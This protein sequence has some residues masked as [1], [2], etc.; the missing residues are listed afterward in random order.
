MI[1]RQGQPGFPLRVMLVA[2]GLDAGLVAPFHLFTRTR[3]YFENATVFDFVLIGIG[4]FIAVVLL[5]MIKGRTFLI[6]AASAAGMA[7]VGFLTIVQYPALEYA[8]Q[9][10][11]LVVFLGI[12]TQPMAV[13][14]AAIACL[15]ILLCS[16][17]FEAC[18]RS[19]PGEGGLVFPAALAL[20]AGIHFF[21]TLLV[22]STTGLMLSLV[23]S[24]TGL[25]IL[26]GK[27]SSSLVPWLGTKPS[28]FPV[29]A[30]RHAAMAITGM[31]SWLLST[32]IGLL[33][34]LVYFGHLKIPLDLINGSLLSSSVIAGAA[35][36]ALIAFVSRK[37]RAWGS[38][39]A[40]TCGGAGLALLF[41]MTST[42][43]L[44][45]FPVIVL[46]IPL[47]LP[48]WHVASELSQAGARG[49]T[50]PL[51]LVGWL[52]SAYVAFIPIKLPDL[53]AFSGWIYIVS[54]AV[55]AVEVCLSILRA[56]L[57]RGAR[58]YRSLQV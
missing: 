3:G 13:H 31:L 17:M 34:M 51:L 55:I 46:G 43:A 18:S 28:P 48:A 39:A 22:P 32:G 40:M 7:I 50:G 24:A 4:V 6:M 58:W 41:Y 38:I 2:C 53:A 12:E 1:Y 35:L 30:G 21:T 23:L 44:V 8:G 5:S 45:I 14:Y 47:V 52:V 11:P 37:G 10:I 26:I 36:A 9:T 16:T 25:I 33:A 15:A 49:M 29:P 42:G 57:A 19:G 54:A 56:Y 27:G 20:G